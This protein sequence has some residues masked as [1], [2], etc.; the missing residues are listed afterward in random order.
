[1]FCINVAFFL[2]VSIPCDLSYHFL[3]CQQGASHAVG[4]ENQSSG[5]REESSHIQESGTA[6]GAGNNEGNYC[7]HT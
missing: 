1:V 4:D 3:G 7:L 5:R 6:T 2:H